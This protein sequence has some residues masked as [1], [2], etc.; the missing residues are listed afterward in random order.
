MF[1][2]ELAGKE[3]NVQVIFR[4][5]KSTTGDVELISKLQM[6][7]ENVTHDIEKIKLNTSIAFMMDFLNNW[8]KAKNPMTLPKRFAQD[9]LKLLAPFAP[10]IVEEIWAMVFHEKSSIHKAPWPTSDKK[11]L[12]EEEVSIPIQVN[13]KVRDVL[14]VSKSDLSEKSVVEKALLSE[15]IAKFV[16]SSKYRVVYRE[17]KILNFILT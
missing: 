1:P 7:I 14:L 13:G 15:K 6:T 17:G 16:S 10:H 5:I 11:L 9:Y 8:E 12:I 2:V 3:G 4:L